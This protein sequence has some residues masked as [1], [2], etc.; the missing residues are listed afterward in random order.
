MSE[1]N[2][3]DLDSV[4]SEAKSSLVQMLALQLQKELKNVAGL[5][6]K[7]SLLQSKLDLISGLMDATKP[8]IEIVEQGVSELQ[9]QN[10][11][12]AVQLANAESK[13]RELAAELS[14]VDKIHNEAVFI[15]DDHYEQ[16]PPEVQKIIRSLA[17]L[18]IPAY[19]AFLAEVRASELDSLAGVA[20]TMLVK[21]SNQSCSSD[22]H[23]VVGWKMVL[24]QAT[25]RAAHIRKGSE[26]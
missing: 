1:F 15:T 19:D 18:Q 9:S 10:A 21:F 2:I 7:N 6:G 5:E 20:E 11:D 13:C 17:V 8:A 25:N 26:L 12:M 16:C 14:A 24:Q 23:E 4:I 22:M 3:E